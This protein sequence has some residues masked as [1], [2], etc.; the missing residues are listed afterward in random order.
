[1]VGRTLRSMISTRSLLRAAAVAVAVATLGAIAPADASAQYFGR[2]KVQY[3][4]F[5]FRSIQTEHF[6]VYHYPEEEAA[7]R[8]AAR[9][10]E[11]WYARL[12]SVFVHEFDERKPIV[13]YAD[14]PDF[15][16]TNTTPGFISEATGGFTEGIKNRVVMPFAETYGDTDH[17][18]GH[19]LVHAFQ[20]DLAQ[21]GMSNEEGP[22]GIHTLPLWAIEGLAEY[23]SLGRRYTHTA[24]WMRDA[25]LRDDVPTLEQL[26]RDP[27]YFPY[28]F[29]HAFW[30]YVGGRWG[31]EVVTALYRSVGARG[32]EGSILRTLGLHPDS[33]SADWIAA[34]KAHYAPLMEGRS[35]PARVGERLIDIEKED[36]VLAPVLSPDGDRVVFI[37]GLDVFTYDLYVADAGTGEVLGK[38]ASASREPHF[39]A[40]AFTNTSGAFSPDGRRFAFVTV[41][42]GDNRI[43]IAD[44][45]SREI[46]Q[47]LA[48][49]DIGAVTSLDWSP[50]GRT[51]VLGGQEGGVPDLWRVSVASGEVERLTDDRFAELHPSF[52]P[53][54]STIAFA[55]D[56]GGEADLDRLR[57]APMGIGLMDAATGEVRRVLRPFGDA[58]HIDP[59]WSPDGTSLFFVSDRAGFSDVFRID[60]A[61]G[62]T[63]QVTNVATGISGITDL[64]PA[65]SV[66]DRSG[67]L[68]FSVFDGGDYVGRTVPATEARGRPVETG[69]VP[70]PAAVLPPERQASRAL[71]ARYLEDPG[72]GLPTTT[73]DAEGRAYDPDLA[74]DY[75]APPT[76]GVG[77]DRFGASVGGSV[78]FFWSDLLG[79]RNMALAVQANGGLEDIGGE[80]L[81]AD[82]DNRLNWGVRAGRIPYRT[83]FVT[84]VPPEEGPGRVIEQNIIRTIYNRAGLM[85]EYPFSMTRR[86]EAEAGFLRV[87]FDH[88]VIRTLVVNGRIVDEIEEDLEAAE[89]LNL[90]TASV[91]FVQDNSF[92][93]FT[94]PVRGGRSR[95]EVGGNV[96]TIDFATFLADWRRYF[97]ARP[98]TVAFRG[99][100]FGRY[101][102]DA[103]SGRLNLMYVGQPSLI[104][105]Y[106][107]GSFEADECTRVPDDTGACPEFDRLVGSKLGVVNAEVRLPLIGTERFGLIEGGF[108]P[109]EL[110]FFVDGGVAWTEGESPEF[111][112]ETESIERIPVFSAGSSLRFN[113]FGRLVGEFYWAYP[114]QRPDAGGQ[115]GFQLVP[116]W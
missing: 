82:L 34:S 47:E 74:L 106:S 110:A 20:Y 44:V 68:A 17:V 24:M 38:L 79:D 85:A 29:G 66:A 73:G 46:G 48:L 92:F 33:L 115:F 42:E 54:G 96:G 43:A 19:E 61:S 67:R 60:L 108:L 1:M 64:A 28:R 88:E 101:G 116:G 18:L 83:G 26:S 53:D 109:T 58:K 103:E 102:P 71:V 84:V 112:F 69:A 105:G 81:Y 55:T 104:R 23:L 49:G 76:A 13:L 40:L 57:L 16:Q 25:V 98:V 77:V 8:D 15:Q 51:L 3:E 52:S 30:G 50:D 111:S 78:G 80:V 65:L 22:A 4:D 5:D 56:R 12:S 70:A 100:H 87:G 93:G 72:T 14:K 7:A 114:F 97:F 91:A 37:S 94:S 27:R 31:D 9:M 63:Y 107:S 62:E 95:F 2:N 89:A 35:E 90:G 75:V 86:I 45:E 32:L 10:A 41:V 113:L 36:W 6:D 21:Q 99:L 11:R 39:D 59:D